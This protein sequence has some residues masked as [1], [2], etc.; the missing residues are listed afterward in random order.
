[1]GSADGVKSALRFETQRTCICEMNPIMRNDILPD[2][3]FPDCQVPDHTGLGGRF[4]SQQVAGELASPADR[5]TYSHEFALPTIHKT[6]RH[7][8]LRARTR[9][10]SAVPN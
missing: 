10:C 5:C 2:T 3:I 4:L 6:E 9:W 1:M 7:P 8:I